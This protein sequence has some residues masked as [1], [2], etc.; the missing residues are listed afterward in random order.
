M[1]K[2]SPMPERSDGIPFAKKSAAKAP[3]KTPVN[4]TRQKLNSV[5]KKPVAVPAKTPAK[6][7]TGTV[8][9]VPASKTTKPDLKKKTKVAA[10]G[11]AVPS[12]KAKAPVA[13]AK[14]KVLPGVKTPTSCAVRPKT[15]AAGK[16]PAAAKAK[17]IKGRATKTPITACGVVIREDGVKKLCEAKKT[18]FL[19]TSNALDKQ[20]RLFT[21]SEDEDDSE[22]EES[23]D[24]QDGDFS[25][26]PEPETRS[27]CD[28][29]VELQVLK[30]TLEASGGVC[31]TITAMIASPHSGLTT[32]DVT[33]FMAPVKAAINGQANL[34]FLDKKINQVKRDEVTAS[35][36][37]QAAK[38]SVGADL[39]AQRVA[40]DEYL[41]DVSVKAP[42]V[43]LS[44][45]LD[46]LVKTMLDTLESQGVA[47]IQSCAGA[48]AAADEKALKAVR[49][50]VAKTPTVASAWADVLAHAAAQAKI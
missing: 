8:A 3:V 37:G 16:A 50:K 49:A 22:S 20:K 27:Q 43:A 17:T 33:K 48:T 38:A 12:A 19:F 25:P 11:K 39:K 32:A 29:V 23:D 31:A 15:A 45:K 10:K 47:N 2:A 30:R 44:K 5:Q 46:T 13:S 26:S 40:V 7:S 35:L 36:K 24:S 21:D 14:P 6:T 4:D 18:S 34:F 9:K 28:H 42:S 41:T 1:T